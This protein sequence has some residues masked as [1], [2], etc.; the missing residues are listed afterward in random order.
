MLDDP[1][2]VVFIKLYLIT[3]EQLIDLLKTTYEV[4]EEESILLNRL[5]DLNETSIV[6]LKKTIKLILIMLNI[7]IRLIASE[8]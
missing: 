1:S 7:T 3:K 2:S 4:S 6:L 5:K 8:N